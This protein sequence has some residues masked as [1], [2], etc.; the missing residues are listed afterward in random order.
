MANKKY[1]LHERR[2]DSLPQNIIDFA[3]QVVPVTLCI[4]GLI[5]L[6]FWLLYDYSISRVLRAV[7]F[8]GF[9]AVSLI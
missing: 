7:S 4:F 3:F 8:N 9:L 6:L 5:K 1:L 2:D